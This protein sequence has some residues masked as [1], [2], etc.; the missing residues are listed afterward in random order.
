MKAKTFG[1]FI[2]AFILLAAI[3]VSLYVLIAY[4]KEVFPENITVHSEGV[5]ESI[6][7]VRD[8]RLNPSESKSYS[9][10]LVCEASGLYLVTLDFIET[11]DGGMKDFV[12]VTV[13]SDGTEVYSGALGKLIS[14]E[15]NA[16][17]E[18]ELS[19]DD[20]VVITVLYQMPRGIGNEAQGTYSDF[21]VKL[22]VK[23]S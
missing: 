18:A 21:D 23:K 1:I 19:A 15:I 3:A 20:P 12:N 11:L 22:S 17:F 16:Q 5:T 6:L 7:P 2:V 13:L 14:G 9:V 8:L 10:N 4:A